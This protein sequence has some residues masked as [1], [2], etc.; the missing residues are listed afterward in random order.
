MA[1]PQFTKLPTHIAFIIDGNGRWA[2]KRGLPRTAGHKAGIDRLK[3]IVYEAFDL[4]IKCVSV[5]C[6]S[7]ENWNRPEK[8]VNYLRNLFIKLLNGKYFDFE[9]RKIRLNVMGDYT[10]FGQEVSDGVVRTLHNTSKYDEHILNLGINYGSRDEL[11]KAF[12]DMQKDGL[13]NISPD[14]ITNYLYTKDLPP[15]DLCVRT[16]G[17]IRLSNF[18]LYQVAYAELYFTSTFWPDFNKRELYK[19]LTDFASRKRRYGAIKEDK[20]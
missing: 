13:T 3:Q 6:F 4:G 20:E 16:S 9:G 15:L 2:K 12:N 1:K 8:E 10:K 11:A 19:A 7:T 18:M 14:D 17:E 5:Y